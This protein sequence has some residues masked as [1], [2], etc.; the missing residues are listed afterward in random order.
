MA[1]DTNWVIMAR[2]GTKGKR[3]PRAQ[4]I[5]TAGHKVLRADGVNITKNANG[6]FPRE[7]V[8]RN[9]TRLTVERHDPIE[10]LRSVRNAQ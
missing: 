3:V 8:T 10:G 5:G 2:K 9:G 7:V 4:G 6:R 1:K